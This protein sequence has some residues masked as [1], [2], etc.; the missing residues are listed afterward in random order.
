MPGRWAG[1]KS[2]WPSSRSMLMWVR[3]TTLL[4]S[5]VGSRLPLSKTMVCQYRV[6]TFPFVFWLCALVL[7]F[8]RPP[9][10]RGLAHRLCLFYFWRMCNRQMR[11]T[12]PR[13]IKLDPCCN[14]VLAIFVR[15]FSLSGDINNLARSHPPTYK[16]VFSCVLRNDV[17]FCCVA[18]AAISWGLKMMLT[19]LTSRTDN[20]HTGDLN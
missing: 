10:A 18:V 13:H 11:P 16:F 5:L 12:S 19:L 8:M 7:V 3:R 17:F 9:P 20:P 4:L 2:H 1:L 6:K 15:Q 14:T